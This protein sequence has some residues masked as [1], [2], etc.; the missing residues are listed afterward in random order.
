MQHDHDQHE[1]WQNELWIDKHIV[2]H[3]IIQVCIVLLL[4]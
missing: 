1:Q 3:N 4:K 2:Y